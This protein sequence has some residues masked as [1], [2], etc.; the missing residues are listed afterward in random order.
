MYVLTL[1]GVTYDCHNML[2][3]EKFRSLSAVIGAGSSA[4]IDHF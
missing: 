2:F 1:L 4:S 3:G